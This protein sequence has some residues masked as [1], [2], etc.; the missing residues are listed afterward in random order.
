MKLAQ[1]LAALLLAPLAAL[2]A[3]EPAQS[4]R[5]SLAATQLNT[6]PGPEYQTAARLYQGIPGITRAKSGRLWATWYS[7][8]KGESKENYVLV[9]TSGDGGKTWPHKLLLDERK[10]VS[11]PDAVAAEDGRLCII[12]DRGRYSEREI[13]SV[14]TSE[15]DIL[16]GQPGPSTK[17]RVILNQATRPRKQ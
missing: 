10:E 8:G 11:Y 15:S 6:A 16:A 12:Y 7:G 5:N 3:A 1:I 4:A 14:V 9:V 17:L 2:Y 13:L